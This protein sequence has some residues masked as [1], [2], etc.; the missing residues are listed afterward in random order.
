MAHLE[1]RNWFEKMRRH[2]PEWFAHVTVL[3]IGSLD[4]NG[5]IRDLY[6]N[7][8]RYVGVDVGPGPGVD[9]VAGGETLEYPDNSFDITVSAECFEHN[10]EWVAT[11]RN[12]HRMA[13]KAVLVTCASD[14]RPE[15][16][17]RNSHP[18]NSPRTLEWDYYRNLNRADFYHEFDLDSMFSVFEFEYNPRSHDLYF[19]GVVK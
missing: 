15:H 9:I 4:I 10:P 16:G 6:D 18:D 5:T 13:S 19:W 2:H 8:L 11:F 3:E 14:G 7:P 1:Q 12:M 17:T